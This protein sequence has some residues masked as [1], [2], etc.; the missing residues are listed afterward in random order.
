[1]SLGDSGETLTRNT[2]GRVS[3]QAEYE[4]SPLR[5]GQLSMGAIAKGGVNSPFE[6]KD[7]LWGSL[8]HSKDGCLT[9]GNG[10]RLSK[11][12]PSFCIWCPNGVR[13]ARPKFGPP[14]PLLRSDPIPATQSVCKPLL[15]TAGLPDLLPFPQS[16]TYPSLWLP[17]GFLQKELAK[18][19]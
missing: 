11:W 18:A 1:M 5:A 16:L 6:M 14:L 2:A 4:L 12:Q 19:S 10:S 7:L 13:K 3:V 9:P 17:L 15:Q 8:R